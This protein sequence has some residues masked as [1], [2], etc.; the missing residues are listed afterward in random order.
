MSQEV[1]D[2]SHEID[3]KVGIINSS[4]GAILFSE[5]KGEAT[6]G[7]S[8]NSSSHRP[9]SARLGPV[10]PSKGGGCPD[11]SSVEKSLT[12]KDDSQI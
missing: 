12:P 7:Q 1:M 10:L 5:K 4:K 3:L 8:K 11:L 6:S 2:S 9:I